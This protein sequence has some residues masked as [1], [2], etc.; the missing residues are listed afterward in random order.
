MN[1]LI[2]A[3]KP[4]DGLNGTDR[5]AYLGFTNVWFGRQYDAEYNATRVFTMTDRPVYRPEH[6]IQFKSWVRHAKYDHGRRPRRVRQPGFQRSSSAIP[7]ATRS[8][9]RRI[10]SDAFGGIEGDLTLAKDATLGVYY[11]QI[12]DHTKVHGYGGSTFRLEEYKKPEFEVKVEAPKE[13]VRLGEKIEATIQAKYYFGAPVTRAKVKYK[14]TRTRHDNSWYPVRGVGLVLRLGLLVVRRR[15]RLVPRL[16]T[17][18]AAWRPVQRWWWGHPPAGAARNRPRERGRDRTRWR[19]QGDDRHRRHQGTARR[20]G[21]Q[22]LASPPKS[23]T[24]RAAPSWAAGNVLVSREPFKVFSWVDRGYYRP[25]DTV[26]AS[27]RG[28]TPDKKPVQG[29]G[30][31]TLYRL[32]YKDGKPVE[33]A[34]QEWEVETDAAGL[35]HG[36]RSTRSRPGSTACRTS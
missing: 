8:T 18:G 33:T 34:A 14:V 7:R 19:R 32:S 13:P 5:L 23:W 20:P 11:I 12:L 31:L 1:W 24:S 22:L 4:K 10:K 16:P 36:S 21:S 30:K 35:R 3:R 6:K 17:C 2:M 25:G 27:F 9:R 28:L 26:K 29:R 15:L